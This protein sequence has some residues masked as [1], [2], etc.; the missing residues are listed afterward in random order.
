MGRTAKLPPLKVVEMTNPSPDV[1][2]AK[3]H[4]SGKTI[5][6]ITHR[7]EHFAQMVAK[8]YNQSQS[9]RAAYNAS[10]QKP[11]SIWSSASVLMTN[12]KV[13]ARVRQLQEEYERDNSARALSRE[14]RVIETL[15]E[16][17]INGH[18]DQSKLKAAELLGKTIALFTERLETQENSPEDVKE[19]EK[20]LDELL[21]RHTD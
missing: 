19:L 3:R 20:Q 18:S 10:N 8:G 5:H 4:K 1:P 16:I 9:Y 7:Q 13:K 14:G 17:M 12:P 15:E 2:R 11:S 21:G 6:G